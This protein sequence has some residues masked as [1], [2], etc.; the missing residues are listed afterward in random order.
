MRGDVLEEFVQYINKLSNEVYDVDRLTKLGDT[1]NHVVE[2]SADKY[3]LPG[4]LA[5][6][7]AV[8]MISN[9]D[10]PDFLERAVKN[11]FDVRELL[12]EENGDVVLMP[13]LH[14]RF[15]N[16][17]YAVWPELKPISRNK[18]IR[19]VQKRMMMNRV[20]TWLRNS[21]KDSLRGEMDEHCINKNIRAP[22]ECL[23]DNPRQAIVT[24]G[25]AIEALDLLNTKR[26]APVT[27]MQHSDLWLG[28]ILFK[29]NRSMPISKKYRFYLIDWGG[30]YTIGAPVLDFIGFC[31]STNISRAKA[32]NELDKYC[33][34]TQI[35][36]EEMVYYL[37]VGLGKIGLNLEQFSEQRFIQMCEKRTSYLIGL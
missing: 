10:F 3:F 4:K 17:S 32:T 7:N 28:N 27:I 31:I 33:N 1:G 15:R 29:K 11:I 36:K 22:L 16:L 5:K 2:D 25:K 14:G 9:E 24:K 20:F 37:L 26:W 18:I 30:A 6:N 19:A 21:A 12:A 8:V 35:P 34:T 23:R 13:L